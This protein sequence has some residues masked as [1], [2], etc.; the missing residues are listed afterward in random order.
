MGFLGPAKAMP[1]P[2]TVCGGLSLLL[3]AVL[4]ELVEVGPD[5]VPVLRFLEADKCHSR[6]RNLH[7]RILD[8]FLELRFV[9]GNAGVLDVVGIA[10]TLPGAGLAAIETIE[11]MPPSMSPGMIGS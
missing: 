3:L 1:V 6:S 5:I 10:V 8:V 11:G 4:V 9:P 2:V 7:L